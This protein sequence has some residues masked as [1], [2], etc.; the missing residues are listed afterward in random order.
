MEYP[1][2]SDRDDR[3]SQHDPAGFRLSLRWMWIA[4]AAAMLAFGGSV[5]GVLDSQGIYG[6]ETWSLFDAAGAQ[7]MVNGLLVSP[8]VVIL[9][10]LARRGSVRSWLCLL[11]FLAF[12]AYNYS[13]YS[14][15][16]HFGPLFLVWVAVLGLSVV[17]LAGSLSGALAMAAAQTEWASTRFP[18]WVMILASTMFAFLWLGEIVGELLS[19][20]PSS[21]AATWK[22]PTNP[23]HVLDL[24]F[25]LP[26]VF[27]SGVLVIRG[28]RWGNATAP[29]SL[30]FLGLTCFPILMT[31]VVSHLRAG[32]GDWAVVLPVGCLAVVLWF[33]LV[34]QLRSAPRYRPAPPRPTTGPDIGP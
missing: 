26:A 32:S 5:I 3:H 34:W 10:C 4:I 7:D 14:F 16:I 20:A 31:P 29:G 33:A 9:A 25:F 13:I 22:V 28:H 27:T 21:S 24:A 23:V 15:S 11:G 1:R 12:T 30:A 18:G 8:L 17:A 6:R 19:G 2:E